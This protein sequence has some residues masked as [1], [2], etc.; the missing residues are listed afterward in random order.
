MLR[1]APKTVKCKTLN[2]TPLVLAL[3]KSPPRQLQTF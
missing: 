1:F 2:G 3:R